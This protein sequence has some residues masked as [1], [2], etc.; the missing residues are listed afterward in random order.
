MHHWRWWSAMQHW[1][2]WRTSSHQLNRRVSVLTQPGKKSRAPQMTLAVPKKH[3]CVFAPYVRANELVSF[4]SLP[5]LNTWRVS[6]LW[7]IVSASGKTVKTLSTHS[8][9]IHS[10]SIRFDSYLAQQAAIAWSDQLFLIWSRRCWLHCCM[11]LALLP[12]TSPIVLTQR[13]K[14]PR[15]PQLPLA[16]H[17]KK[18]VAYFCRMCAPMSSFHSV[19]YLV[20]TL[21]EFHCCGSWS[22]QVERV[23]RP[24]STATHSSSIHILLS[25]STRFDSYLA[26]RTAIAWSGYLCLIWSLAACRSH[27][28]CQ[29]PPRSFW[30]NVGRNRG[31]RWQCTKKRCVFVPYV[32]ANELVSFSSLPVLNTWRVSL[33][34][35]I[36][37]A[38]GKTVKQCHA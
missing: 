36:V 27:C 18:K 14:K 12:G 9:S 20:W 35:F 29:V 26:Q 3:R 23:E 32:R 24:S 28:C 5:V 34:W 7:F 13:G 30:P 4:S 21:E 10:I 33:L 37:S 1:R 15:A 8:S 31:W 25:I 17:E 38:G 19:L 6:L 11:S 22:V 16:A 2:S